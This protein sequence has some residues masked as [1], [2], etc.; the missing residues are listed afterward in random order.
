MFWNTVVISR[1]NL[2]TLK[3]SMTQ[4]V[5]EWHKHIKY[6]NFKESYNYVNWNF[7]SSIISRII[8]V[9]SDSWLHAWSSLVAHLTSLPLFHPP[10]LILEYIYSQNTWLHSQNVFIEILIYSILMKNLRIIMRAHLMIQTCATQ[11]QPCSDLSKQEH[12]PRSTFIP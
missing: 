2:S 12:W 11:W 4:F 7:E 10:S 5:L 6:L 3:R 1:L 8:N 9:Y